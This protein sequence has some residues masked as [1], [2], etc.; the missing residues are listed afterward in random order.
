MSAK[1]SKCGRVCY[2]KVCMACRIAKADEMR[3]RVA[4]EIIDLG[5]RPKEVAARLGKGVKNVEGLWA[6]VQRRI[7]NAS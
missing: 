1:C 7:R 3:F 6:D 2:G 5:F 4:R